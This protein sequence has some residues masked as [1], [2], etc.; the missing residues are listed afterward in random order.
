MLFIGGALA[1]LVS[2]SSA[3]IVAPVTT[4]QSI[5]HIYIPSGI[6]PPG[7]MISDTAVLNSSSFNSS[8]L[9]AAPNNRF[10]AQLRAPQGF[11][12]VAAPAPAPYD[13][14]LILILSWGNSSG[15]PASFVPEPAVFENLVGPAPTT[16]SQPDFIDASG[17]LVRAR[18]NF[19]VNDPFEFT[20]ITLAFSYSGTMPGIGGMLSP[21]PFFGATAQSS[22]AGLPDASLLRLVAVPEPRCLV[23]W[24]LG[25]G[26]IARRG[27][28]LSR[29]A[30]M[31]P[32]R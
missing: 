31:N 27:A 2:T 18:E 17:S 3:E 13:T 11:K 16:L 8:S 5:S 7:S 1:L 28:C 23:A 21:Q 6:N 10:V 29:R 25:M 22:Q 9:T 32:V 30:K 19:D 15:T 20:A 26:L 4:A 24:L 12:F 14:T